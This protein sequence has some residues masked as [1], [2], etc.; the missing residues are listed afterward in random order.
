MPACAYWN[1][2][3]SPGP[4]ATCAPAPPG[5]KEKLAS[6]KPAGFWNLK[7]TLS[8]TGPCSGVAVITT[9]EGPALVTVTLADTDLPLGVVTVAVSVL[10]P[11]SSGTAFAK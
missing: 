1:A 3:N 9:G 5:L 6:A 10:L 7:P 2:K 11:G 8:G 4:A